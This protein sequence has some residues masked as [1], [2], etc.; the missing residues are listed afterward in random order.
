MVMIVI[1]DV[2]NISEVNFEYHPSMTD[3][4]DRD[5]IPW[6]E[7]A[8]DNEMDIVRQMLEIFDALSGMTH[9]T[10]TGILVSREEPAAVGQR[11]AGGRWRCG[12]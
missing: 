8:E 9:V 11:S 10:C 1:D 5:D 2:K 7:E 3:L 4:P 6:M 12:Q